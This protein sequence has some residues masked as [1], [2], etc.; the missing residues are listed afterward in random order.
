VLVAAA[1]L[2]VAVAL[3]TEG[4]SRSD[5]DLQA[6]RS[7]TRARSPSPVRR[8]RRSDVTS[9]STRVELARLVGQLVVGR[10]TGPRLSAA[11]L[12]R[13]RA[14]HLGAV[15][16]FS[17]NTAAGPAATRGAIA[18]LQ[19]AARDGGNPPLLVMTD[20]EGGEVRRLPG[21]PQLAPAQMD[22]ASV[23]RAQ[24]AAAGRLLR[25]V[26]IDVDLAPVADVERVPGSFLGSR[27]FGL[28]PAVVAARACAFASGLRSAG[29][30]Y[31]LK[32]FPGLG[33]ASASTDTEPVTI[34]APAADLRADYA[35]YR[36][37]G[38]S[39]DALV[40]VSSAV[41]PRLSGS[42]PAVMSRRVYAHELPLA[43][44]QAGHLTISDAL[45]TPAFAGHKAPALRA[46]DAGLDLALFPGGGQESAAAYAGL[47]AA[48]RRGSLP[49]SRL[50][51]A[52]QAVESLKRRLAR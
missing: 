42:T 18:E 51:S 7:Y 5:K 40:M 31:T 45:D 37:C 17:D 34:G 27:S 38:S 24:G 36:S 41:Y 46:I 28:N 33:R 2:G 8:S 9:G 12:A 43:L 20:Q 14:G 1:A 21:P 4:S 29:V 50:R 44:G 13:V 3:L 32:H 48:A 16:L 6:G 19:A 39:P 22:S 47:L 11:F 35:A 49:E 23:A 26:G 30:A 15:I 25:S 52:V 10:Y